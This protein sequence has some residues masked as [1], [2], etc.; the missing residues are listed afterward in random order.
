MAAEAGREVYYV[1]L[2]RFLGCTA[3]AD[4]V[5]GLASGNEIRFLGRDDSGDDGL[6]S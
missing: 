6:T 5:A 3:D 1:S 2:L 4:Q